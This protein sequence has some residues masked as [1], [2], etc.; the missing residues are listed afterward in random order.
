[1]AWNVEMELISVDTP[2]PDS[3]TVTATLE[4]RLIDD[5]GPKTKRT[6]TVTVDLGSNDGW[7]DIDDVLRRKYDE[8]MAWGHYLLAIADIQKRVGSKFSTRIVTTAEAAVEPRS[9]GGSKHVR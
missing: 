2:G 6:R 8:A 9:D 3:G 4:W 5:S 1:M 7:V